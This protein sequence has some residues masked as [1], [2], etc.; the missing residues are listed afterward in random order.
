MR[1]LA[2]ALSV[3]TALGF[4]SSKA[5]VLDEFL[6]HTGPTDGNL[7]EILEENPIVVIQV[8]LGGNVVG[9]TETLVYLDEHPEKTIVIDG[10]C[11]SACT[12]L[13]SAQNTLI[14]KNARLFYHSSSS[15]VCIMGVSQEVI[16]QDVNMF[17][18]ST[19]EPNIQR[20][21]LRTKAFD[22]TLFTEMPK[23]LVQ[24]YYGYKLIEADYLP[25]QTRTAIRDNDPNWDMNETKFC[26]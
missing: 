18:L 16:S 21:I 17:M 8:G 2:F 14:T 7:V 10:E 5:K 23:S 9:M 12:M 1:K 25:K 13:L 24:S 19:Y 11:F 6:I 4:G 20:W 22:T 15:T 3:I 26:D